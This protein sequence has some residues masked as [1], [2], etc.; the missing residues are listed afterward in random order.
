MRGSSGW[1]IPCWKAS[2][3]MSTSVLALRLRAALDQEEAI[4][5]V[6]GVEP[7]AGARGVIAAGRPLVPAQRAHVRRQR[8]RQRV[9][10]HAEGQEAHERRR[11]EVQAIAATD[12]HRRRERL[13]RI[14]ADLDFRFA[15]IAAGKTRMPLDG[16]QE[17]GGKCHAG[18]YTVHEGAWLPRG[19]AAPPLSEAGPAA[20]LGVR[21]VRARAR[22]SAWSRLASRLLA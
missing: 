22:A 11:V 3:S 9:R 8:V 19:A 14:D 6:G 15:A 16:G 20:S 10:R 17:R 4:A 1:T 12:R 7:E 13:R 21:D 18:N 5:V 2:I